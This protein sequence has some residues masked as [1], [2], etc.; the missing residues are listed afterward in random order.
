M[1]VQFPNGGVI[2]HAKTNQQIWV[3]FSSKFRFDWLQN[4][5]QCFST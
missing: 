5:R 3:V 2:R 4:L 1:L